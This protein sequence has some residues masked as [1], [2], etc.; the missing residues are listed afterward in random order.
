MRADITS[1]D[2]DAL[3]RLTICDAS[4]IK[5]NSSYR[6]QTREKRISGA[7]PSNR[8]STLSSLKQSTERTLKA[9]PSVF[10]YSSDPLLLI[11]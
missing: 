9:G 5:W 6:N 7:Q 10:H 3:V 8:E 4:N 1:F 2:I 11:N